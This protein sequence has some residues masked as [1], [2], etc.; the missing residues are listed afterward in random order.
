[1]GDAEPRAYDPRDA[2]PGAF[3]APTAD[4]V[5][6]ADAFEALREDFHFNL[7]LLGERDAHID[8]LEHKL[9]TLRATLASAA[10]HAA[11]EA[12]EAARARDESAKQ[13]DAGHAV[14]LEQAN[15]QLEKAKAE[16]ADANRK[17]EASERVAARARGV[18]DAQA[19]RAQTA[20]AI[21]EAAREET[22]EA[23][24]LRDACDAQ[25]R[26]ERDRWVE[27]SEMQNA[28]MRAL[29]SRIAEAEALVNAQ[30]KEMEARE[31]SREHAFRT[32]IEQAEGKAR[33][34][35]E[36]EFATRLE[37]AEN[38]ACDLE[39]TATE[40]TAASV[41][42]RTTQDV[43]EERL[44]EA[45]V[46]EDVQDL[47]E[48][49]TVDILSST[50]ATPPAPASTSVA[51]I[52]LDAPGSTALRA[53]TT[54][55]SHFQS[56][57]GTAS[58]VNDAFSAKSMGSTKAVGSDYADRPLHEVMETLATLSKRMDDQAVSAAAALSPHANSASAKAALDCVVAATG[59]A[60]EMLAEIEQKLVSAKARRTV[61][62][63]AVR[64]VRGGVGAQGA[65]TT[66]TTS[67]SFPTSRPSPVPAPS[68]SIPAHDTYGNEKSGTIAAAE[69]IAARVVETHNDSRNGIQHSMDPWRMPVRARLAEMSAH[70]SRGGFGSFQARDENINAGGMTKQSKQ[71]NPKPKKKPKPKKSKTFKPVASRATITAL[72][73][74]KQRPDSPD[75]VF[76]PP[77]RARPVPKSTKL[78]HV[79]PFPASV[80]PEDLAEVWGEEY[81]DGSVLTSNGSVFASLTPSPLLKPKPTRSPSRR[82]I[83]VTD[84]T[85]DERIA[86]L[87]LRRET[88]A[89]A[90]EGYGDY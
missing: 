51:D 16:T 19:D 11:S 62:K 1:M 40:S 41:S 50:P 34:N 15:V 21:C 7:K 14:S 30:R 58:A 54:L 39:T 66:E 45:R 28:K 73:V 84:E 57:P 82:S 83:A 67:F 32:A 22:Q 53:A 61:R 24:R 27:A 49:T 6:R 74:P 42:V 44:Q 86:A 77:F 63:S 79:G 12:L 56:T 68:F 89:A 70:L 81:N 36:A 17:R 48:S 33:A 76:P 4:A 43:Q 37:F 9:V 13:R 47:Q 69:A 20:E 38:R 75:P 25:W 29:E 8:T 60:A 71:S 55:E 31:R 2:D 5:E 80:E 59:Y 18:A 64:G 85:T 3:Q 52:P 90:R 35:I 10:E 23:L 87:R 65:E 88:F 72:S 26:D 46:D 78:R